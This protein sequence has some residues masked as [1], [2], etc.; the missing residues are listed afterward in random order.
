MKDW[1]FY[2]LVILIVGA[3]IA[4]ALSFADKA[5]IDTSNGIELQGADLINLVVAPGTS[6]EMVE[7]SEAGQFARLS[8]HAMHKDAPSAGIFI[9][10][11]AAYHA[12]YNGRNVKFEIEA[13][14]AA[15]RGADTF[16][17]ALFSPKSSSGWKEINVSSEFQAWSLTHKLQRQDSGEDYAYF[18]IWPDPE[19]KGK[20][21]DVRSVRIVPAG[22]I[23]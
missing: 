19:G 3:M 14:Q 5:P 16:W 18:G 20:F 10:L 7:D 22:E 4:L 17:M 6:L 2:P 11:P 1:V 8:A 21:I 15:S 13:R 23:D 12:A 9:A